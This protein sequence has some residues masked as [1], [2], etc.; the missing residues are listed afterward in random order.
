MP[1]P[2]PEELVR[3]VSEAIRDQLARGESVEMP[4]LGTFSVEHRP[5][6]RTEA[7][8]RTPPRT[9]VTFHPDDATA[10]DQ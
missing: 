4:A 5:S 7:A 9:V 6:E 1:S 3:A 10:S 2:T 8:T